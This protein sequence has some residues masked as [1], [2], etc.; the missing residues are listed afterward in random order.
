MVEISPERQNE[1]F[2]QHKEECYRPETKVNVK[3]FGKRRLSLGG[4]RNNII[5]LCKLTLLYRGLNS[6]DCQ[7]KPCN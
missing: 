4:L 1:H 6:A 5:L 2:F 3:D 7:I